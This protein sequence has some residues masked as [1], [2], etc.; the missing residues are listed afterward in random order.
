MQIHDY[1]VHVDRNDVFWMIPVRHDAVGVDFDDA[2]A[3]LRVRD[4]TVFDD[5]DLANS[6]T[7]GLGLPANPAAMPPTPAIPGMF[8]V[9]AKVSF[10]VE[11][12]GALAMAEIENSSQNFKGSFLSTGATIRWSAEQPGFRFES[13]APP[14]PNANLISVLGRERNGVFFS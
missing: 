2:R 6:L 12:N 13:D 14:D 9:R 8:P 7:Q 11:W 5:H 10:D 3:R 1:N 4:L